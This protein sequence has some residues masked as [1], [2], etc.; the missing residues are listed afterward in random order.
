[1]ELMNYL[2]DYY[3]NSGEVTNIQSSL[4]IE[5]HSLKNHITDLLNQLFID[6]ATWGLK[7]WERELGLNIDEKERLDSR[8]A[9]IKTRLRGQGTI[10]NDT[11]KNICCSFSGGEV[12][13]IENTSNYEIVIKF[14][15]TIGVPSNM[16]YLRD[17]LLNT[18]PA[19][20]GFRFEYK[21]N[22]NRDIAKLTNLQLQ[23]FTHYQ[24]KNQK[25]HA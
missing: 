2:P 5:S 13:I 18:L 19:H 3:L 20:L 1:M 22:T 17:T 21:F 8:R 25:L 24:L 16:D 15:G 14:V 10:T 4:N 23:Q 6:T 9:R 12:E 11:I 7:Y